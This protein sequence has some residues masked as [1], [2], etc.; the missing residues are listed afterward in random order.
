M[1][2]KILD[3]SYK[4]SN[5][6]DNMTILDIAKLFSNIKEKDYSIWTKIKYKIKLSVSKDQFNNMLHL[7]ELNVLPKDYSYDEK[8]TITREEMIIIL[9]NLSKQL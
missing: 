3:T 4:E 8:S 1:A 9:D 7:Y 2:N 5:S 6:K